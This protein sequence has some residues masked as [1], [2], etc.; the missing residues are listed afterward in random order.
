MSAKVYYE[1]HSL[2]TA[3]TPYLVAKGWTGGELPAVREGFQSEQDIKIPMVAV[4]F[5]PRRYIEAQLGRSVTSEKSYLRRIQLDMYMSSEPKAIAIV[6]DL[7]DFLDEMFIVITDPNSIAL[8]N[9]YCNNSETILGDNIPPVMTQPRVNRWR[10]VITAS[11]R[12]DY[13]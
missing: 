13:Y 3:I 9:L 8:G 1:R 5:L 6:D 11:L 4:T 2:A 7:M 10:G 12:S